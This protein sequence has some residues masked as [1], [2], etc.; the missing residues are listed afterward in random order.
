M[1][2]TH[3]TTAIAAFWRRKPPSPI[4]DYTIPWRMGIATIVL[5]GNEL[6]ISSTWRAQTTVS[7]HGSPAAMIVV[8]GIFSGRMTS[9]ERAWRCSMV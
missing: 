5:A 8:A 2:K 9:A 6:I 1:S 4:L 3:Q 7:N